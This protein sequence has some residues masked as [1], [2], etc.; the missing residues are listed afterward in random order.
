MYIVNQQFL[1]NG[2]F[3]TKVFERLVLNQINQLELA[4][5]C[6][7]TG[8]GQRGFKKG[9]GTCS[10]GLVLQSLVARALDDDN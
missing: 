4:G 1:N 2:N 5:S 3:P 10:A 8:N 6:D 9:R 7:L